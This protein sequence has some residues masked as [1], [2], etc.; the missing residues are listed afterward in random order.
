MEWVNPQKRDP[1]RPSI[2]TKRR[3][4]SPLWMKQ[5]ICHEGIQAGNW[6]KLWTA[7]SVIYRS[8]WSL[9]S[10]SLRGSL[11]LSLRYVKQISELKKVS[12]AWMMPQHYDINKVLHDNNGRVNNIH[13]PEA[14]HWS[15]TLSTW[16]SCISWNE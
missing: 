2:V 8:G 15:M 12:K 6:R 3:D 1:K 4:A 10:K 9:S 16:E 14:S 11:F 7:I 5:Q 13:L